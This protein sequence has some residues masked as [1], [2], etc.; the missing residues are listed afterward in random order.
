MSQLSKV[1]HSRNQWKH[2][3]KERGDQDRYRRKQLARVKAERDQ[4]KQTLKEVQAR[5]RQLESQAQ[6]VVVLPKVDVVWMS[7]QLFLEA[8]ISFR[9]VSRVLTLL[10]H[11]LGLKKRA[12]LEHLLFLGYCNDYHQYFPTIEAVSE[13][14]YGTGKEVSPVEVGAGERIIDRALL[15][16]YEMAGKIRK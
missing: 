14:G 15:D 8:H 9:A 12:R 2:K 3:A 11:A 13:G 1:K 5:L 6:A 4:A 10:T 16:L 7:L